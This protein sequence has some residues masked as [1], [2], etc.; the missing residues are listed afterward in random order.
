MA[1]MAF[2]SKPNKSKKQQKEEREEF[3][4]LGEEEKKDG[5]LDSLMDEQPKQNKNGKKRGKGNN[6][7][8]AV[9]LK[10]GFF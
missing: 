5:G 2:D 1:L 10:V 4:T 7:G 9:P 3:P 6:K 8:G